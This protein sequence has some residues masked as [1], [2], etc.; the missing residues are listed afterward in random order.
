MRQGPSSYDSRSGQV[1]E[2]NANVLVTLQNPRGDITQV[3]PAVPPS[4][5]PALR[6]DLSQVKDWGKGQLWSSSHGS[7]ASTS[8]NDQGLLFTSTGS[9]VFMGADSPVFSDL[10]VGWDSSA[11]QRVTI[12]N[13]QN[14]QLLAFLYVGVPSTNIP[15]QLRPLLA[16]PPLP[17]SLLLLF[18]PT[19]RY[20]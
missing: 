11:M 14:H 20:S 8:P 7:F 12:T 16:A 1:A 15:E 5:L 9:P 3:M 2:T 17:T 19:R 13:R 4:A 18:S 6:F 10:E